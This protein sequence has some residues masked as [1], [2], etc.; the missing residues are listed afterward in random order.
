MGGQAGYWGTASESQGSREWLPVTGGRVGIL[1]GVDTTGGYSP[2]PGYG[3]L[4]SPSS[5][6]AGGSTDNANGATET[7]GNPTG[8]RR[9]I[10]GAAGT[11]AQ[12][13]DG[14]AATNCHGV[15]ECAPLWLVIVDA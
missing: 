3:G 12:G 4:G 2:R 8:G 14:S 6:S 5:V 11:S 15:R 7:G 1:D 13:P 10:G 9:P